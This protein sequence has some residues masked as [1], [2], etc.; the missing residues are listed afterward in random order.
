M[1]FATG[2]STPLLDLEGVEVGGRTAIKK[3]CIGPHCRIGSGVKLTNCILMDHVVV[4]DKVTM[5]N[6][7]VCSNAE[8]GEGASLKDAQVGMGVTIEP[9][10]VVKGEAI[11]NDREDDE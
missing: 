4:H 5:S 9:G 11:D 7:I 2:G 8:V 3:S 1:P 6:C 10:A